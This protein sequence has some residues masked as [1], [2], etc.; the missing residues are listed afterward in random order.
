M[1]VSDESKLVSAEIP[2][3]L[4]VKMEAYMRLSDWDGNDM[5]KHALAT[6]FEVAE[7]QDYPP[8]IPDPC[9]AL[10]KLIRAAQSGESVGK[11]VSLKGS[12]GKK[13]GLTFQPFSKDEVDDALSHVIPGASSWM[14]EL[15][16]QKAEDKATGDSTSPPAS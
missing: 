5:V 14:V 12:G 6:L 7:S 2:P 4:L 9:L 10:G 11:P 16:K 13:K 1:G 8:A 15:D 3:K